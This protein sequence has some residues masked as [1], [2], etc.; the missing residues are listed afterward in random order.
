MQ[1]E[2]HYILSKVAQ[3]ILVLIAVMFGLIALANY[4]A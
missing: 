4:I 2:D 1:N 3:T